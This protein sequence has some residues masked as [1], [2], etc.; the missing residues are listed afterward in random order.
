MFREAGEAAQ[1][2]HDQL[3]RNRAAAEVLGRELR[4]HHRRGGCRLGM[5]ARERRI[6]ASHRAS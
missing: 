6:P 2:V 3:T 1:A 4:A 5:H